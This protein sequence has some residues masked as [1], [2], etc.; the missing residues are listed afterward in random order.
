MIPA[1]GW[2]ILGLGMLLTIVVWRML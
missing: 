1:G 2:L